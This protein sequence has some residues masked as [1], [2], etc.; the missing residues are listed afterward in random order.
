MKKENTK[1]YLS[2]EEVQVLKGFAIIFMFIHH[3]FTF[4]E[5]HAEYIDYPY[6]NDKVQY[7]REPFKICVCIFAFLTG[8]TYFYVKDKCLKYSAKK[9]SI[10]L[11]NYWM[12]YFLFE[13]IGVM[14]GCTQFEYIK[15]F[16]GC[17][18][19][20]KSVMIFCWYVFFYVIMMLILPYLSV[21]LETNIFN[22][23]LSGVIIPIIFL[24]VLR[25]FIPGEA[26]ESMAWDISMFIPVICVGYIH[27][28]YDMFYT[29]YDAL[30]QKIQMKCFKIITYI[31][32]IVVAIW[33][34]YY[35]PYIVVGRISEEYALNVNMDIFY[36][37]MFIYACINLRRQINLKNSYI[38]SN[39]GKQSLLM[40]FISC[41]FFDELKTIFQP[42]LYLPQ[43]PILVLIW[44]AVLCYL[45]ALLLSL[46]IT[47]LN[48]IVEKLFI[49]L[50]GFYEKKEENCNERKVENP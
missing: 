1:N 12:V 7:F 44:G 19:L 6:I 36:A 40:W 31:V 10:F 22:A 23:F 20:D 48:N 26:F 11:L 18:G 34:R 38:M 17:L 13:I 49:K 29:L 41:I 27:A 46:I 3:F 2:K 14:T 32:M 28:K 25:K 43:N 39:L 16:K 4:P 15:F 50:N 9:I 37:P 47:P 35:C 30:F 45:F 21:L 42:V 24:T 33:G 8:Y 5:W